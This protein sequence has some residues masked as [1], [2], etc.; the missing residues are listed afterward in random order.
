MNAE[1]RA[2]AAGWEISAAMY[3]RAE[4]RDIAFLRGGGVSQLPEEQ[5]ALGDLGWCGA[6][7]HLQCAGGL[8][9][10]SLLNLGAKSVA[11]ID[12]SPRMVASARRRAAA[13]DAPATFHCCDVVEAP[14][15]LDGSADLVH[16]G[17]G[18]LPWLRDVDAWARTAFRLLRPG[19]VLHVY[20]GHPLD[21]VWDASAG[22]FRLRPGGD[23]FSKLTNEPDA[24][25]TPLIKDLGA[26]VTMYEYQRTLG[27]VITAVATTGLRI[28]RVKE[29]PVQYWELFRD[30]PPELFARLPH[31]FT[32]VARKS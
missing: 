12:I 26:E 15:V 7:I 20:E 25:P 31:S 24:W 30:I 18:A 16:T 13:L 8:D 17:R 32:I 11:G 4:E 22:E 3:E 2:N 29:H 10:L 21:R 27:D 14:A 28:E 19:G 6:A 23:Y 5:A 9:T 1:H